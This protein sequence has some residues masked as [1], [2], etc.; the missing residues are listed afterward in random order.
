MHNQESIFIRLVNSTIAGTGQA[1]R[2]A[3]IFVLFFYYYDDELTVKKN[4]YF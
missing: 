3:D 2:L 1:A 4:H